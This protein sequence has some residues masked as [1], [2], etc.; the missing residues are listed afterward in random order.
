MVHKAVFTY[1]KNLRNNYNDIILLLYCHYYA[2]II[3]TFCDGRD[4]LG[5]TII[6]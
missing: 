5:V 4:F 2:F 3:I 6:T 1:H